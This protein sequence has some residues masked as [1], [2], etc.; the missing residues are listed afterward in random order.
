[1]VRMGNW[2]TYTNINRGWAPDNF[3][4]MSTQFPHESH[5]SCYN[6]HFQAEGFVTATLSSESSTSVQCDMLSICSHL[7]RSSAHHLP[8]LKSVLQGGKGIF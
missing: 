4:S 8:V 7:A 1:M 3:L 2:V 6:I 5:N